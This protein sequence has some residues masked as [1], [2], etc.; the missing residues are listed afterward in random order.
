MNLLE[1]LRLIGA[2]S[3]HALLNGAIDKM[4][5]AVLEQ[6]IRDLQNSRKVV[7]QGVTTAVAEIRI[8]T[9]DQ[10]TKQERHTTLESV[11]NQLLT[12]DNPAN[13]MAAGPKE[14][15]QMTIEAE[16]QRITADLGTHAETK[17]ALEQAL[18]L[19]DGRISEMEARLNTLKSTE[20]QTMAKEEASKAL[21]LATE[22]LGSGAGSSIDSA[23]R[24]AEQRNVRAGVELES[25]VSELRSKS[26][27]ADLDVEVQARLAARKGRLSG[28]SAKAAAVS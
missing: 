21:K 1:K 25:E 19:V 7:A 17:G 8:L 18:V 4:P 3:L 20:K 28:T 11:I 10:R 9:K 27:D 22:V 5:V 12:D 26:G 6:Q 15:E 16:L 24:R 13:D 14:K 2:G 23:M